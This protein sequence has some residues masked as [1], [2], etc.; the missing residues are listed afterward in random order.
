VKFSVDGWDP[1]YGQ[2][3]DVEEILV[4]SNAA[5]NV[6]LEIAE[7]DWKP[8]PASRIAPPA[9]VLFVDGVRRIDARVWVEGTAV[10]DP[11]L[12]GIC[13]S[14]SAGVVCC[15][16][17]RAHIVVA[18][19]RR[20][21][22]TLAGHAT[23]VSTTAGTYT[24]C[25]TA[26]CDGVPAIQALSQALQARMGEL[27]VVTALDARA[28]L[29]AHGIKQDDDLL[30]VDGPLRGRT[31]LPRA[32]G[33][34]KTH[35]TEYLPP[36][37]NAVVSQMQLGERTP[38]FLL[39]SSWDRH[40]WY[41]RL[42]GESKAPWAGVVRV[43]CSADLQRDVVI[44]LADVSQSILPRYASAEHKDPRAPQNLYPIGG[45]ERDLRHRL[46]DPRV[47]FRALK[48]ASR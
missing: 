7:A 2:A 14:Y 13:A 48:A 26:V 4:E 24:A 21:L 44:A 9:A 5:V 22:F 10:T 29:P 15:C 42:P 16:D 45:L 35:R 8:I 41:L 46:G 28:S 43:E 27:E 18:E 33:F 23:D 30:V 25:H 40:A 37:L 32:L 3:F 19:A 38:V 6:D 12:A 20:G 1:S 47:L 11:P 31:H 34:I 39:G 17:G 36:H